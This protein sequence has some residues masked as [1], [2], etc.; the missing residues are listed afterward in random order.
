[1]PFQ[2][3]LFTIVSRIALIWIKQWSVYILNFCQLFEMKECFQNQKIQVF[4]AVDYTQFSS[5]HCWTVYTTDSRKF[6]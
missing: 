5:S 6:I 4:E 2:I 3:Q 1:M